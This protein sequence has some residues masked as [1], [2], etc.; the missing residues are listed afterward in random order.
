[1]LIKRDVDGKA[2]SFPNGE[3]PAIIGTFTYTAK[4]MGGAPS[5]T[6]TIYYPTPLD[7]QWTHEEYVEFQGE[8]YYA[9]SIPSSSK[10][11]QSVLYKHDV[12]F[13]SRREILDN[14]L[15]FDAV[16]NK[17][18]DT[19]GGDKY[20]TN[21][22]RFSF[23]GDITEFVSRINSS[24]KYCDV[25]YSVVIDDGYANTDV[26]EVSFENQYLT[27]VLQLINT[28]YQ[29]DYY[30]V[31]NV[32]HVGKLQYDL[33]DNPIEYGRNDA[34]V[35]VSKGNSNARIVDMITGYGSSDNIPYYYPNDD[36]FGKADYISENINEPIDI[37][38]SQ[39]QKNANIGAD[40][41][42]KY[43]LYKREGALKATINIDGSFFGTMPSSELVV[44]DG[45][46]FA[47]IAVIPIVAKKGMKIYEPKITVSH[48]T[49]KSGVSI[50]SDVFSFYMDNDTEGKYNGS[51]TFTND[52]YAALV[53]WEDI[54]IKSTI[55]DVAVDKS[56]SYNYIG[57]VEIE[58]EN[59]SKAFWLFD[60]GVIEY[61]SSGISV[62]NID[63]VTSAKS[64]VTFEKI[65]NA[66]NT[67]LWWGFKETYDTSTEEAAAKI[68]IKGR[69]WIF[70][71]Q[72]LMPS[73]YRESGGAERFYYAKNDTYSIPGAT[74]KYT[75]KNIYKEGNPHQGSVEFSDI[76]PTINGVRND[77]I[78][79]D[80]LGQLFGE[81]AGV[82]FDSNDSD[83]KNDDSEYIH[84]Y[85]YIKL[86]KFSGSYGFD[87]FKHALAS[88]SAKINLIKSNGCP[89]CSFDIQCVP[90]KDKSKMYNC[91]S[92]D[93]HGNLKSVRDDCNDYIFKNDEDA[94]K[95]TFNQDS[96]KTELWIAVKKDDSTL[97]IIMPNASGNFKPQKGD[98]FVITG[99]NPPKVLVTAAEKRLDDALIKYMS[100]N[101]E[102]KFNY[103]VKFSRIFLQENM[104]FAN[105]LNENSKVA[106]TYAGEK[107]EFFV[108]NYT[109]KVDD[110][111]LAD[112]EIELSDTLDASSS[113]LKKAID[114]VKG[115]TVAQL[116]GLIG[117]SGGLNATIANRLYL[118]KQGDDTAQ[119][120]ITF[121][122][123]LISDVLAK[124]NGGATFGKGGYKFDEKGNVVVDALSSLAFDEALERGFGVTKNSRGKYTLSVTDLMVWGKAVFNSLEIR[125]LYAVGGNVY[126]S[127]ASSKIVRAVPVKKATDTASSTG[128]DASAAWVACAEGDAD[129]EGWKCYTLND[130][131]TTATQNGWRKYDQA[132]C[133]TFDIEAGAHEGVSNTYYWRLVA[134][135]SM[136]NET[137][138]ETRTET[139]VDDDGVT[140]TREVT[141]DLYDGKKF[142]W[143]ILSKTDCES[144]GN[145]APKAGDTIVLD[146]HRMFASGDADG[147]DQY[148]DESRTNVMMLETTGTENGTLPRIVALTGIV[149]YRHWD[150]VN[151]YSNTV[152]ILSPKEVVFVSSSFK[153]MSA[154]GDPITLVNFR[155]NWAK[156]TKYGYYDQVSHNDSIWTCIVTKGD[157]TNEEPSDTS[158]VWRKEI[159]GGKGDPAVTYELVASPSY[160][161]LDADGSFDR[162]NQYREGQMLL[163]RGYKIVGGKRI[164][165][166]GDA[167]NPIS[168]QISF[169]DGAAWYESTF[170]QG[171]SGL[172]EVYNDFEP[173]CEDSYFSMLQ[174]M[175]KNGL[176]NCK[177]VMYEG[178]SLDPDK[179]PSDK[180]LARID[181]PIVQDGKDGASGTSYGVTL[182][183]EKRT[184]SSV[185]DDCLVVTFTKGDTDGV[186]TTN[187]VQD[188]GGYAQLYVDGKIDTSASARLN[189]GTSEAGELQ[190][191]AF[192][193]V[194]T[195]G[196]VTVKWYDKEGG[197]LLGTG[198]LTRGADGKDATVY[199]VQV[200]SYYEWT[201]GGKLPGLEFG[202]TKTTGATVGKVTDVRNIGCTVMIYGD[203]TYYSSAS[204]W[205]NEGNGNFL[206]STFPYGD[207]DGNP[208][209]GDASVVCVELYLDGMLVATANY[210]NGK[211]GADGPAATVYTIEAVGNYN[212]NSGT[213][214]DASTIGV[215]LT[216][217]LKLYKTVGSEKTEDSKPPQCWRLTVGGKNVDG[218]IVFT[219][220]A[221]NNIVT[222]QYYNTYKKDSNGNIA[223]PGSATI[224]VYKDSSMG[225]LLASLVIPITLNPGAIVNVDA[226]LGKI[227][228][229][230]ASMKGTIETIQQG[231]GQISL[232][233]QGLERKS[234]NILS[235]GN[236]IGLFNKQYEVFR[237]LPF[238]MEK[239]RTY[240][241]TARLWMESN[242]NERHVTAFVFGSDNNWTYAYSSAYFTKT[243]ADYLRF[244]FEA[245]ATRQMVVAFYEQNSSRDDPGSGNYNGVHV[246]WVRV[247]EGDWTGVD[248]N[249]RTLDKWEPSEEETNAVNLLPDPA[250]SASIGYTDGMG[251]RNTFVGSMGDAVP[252]MSRDPSADGDGCRGV[253]FERSG[254]SDPEGANNDSYAGL[255]YIVP[256]RGAGTYCISFVYTDLSQTLS[257]KPDMD[258]VVVMEVHP[259]DADKYRIT[260]GFNTGGRNTSSTNSGII[261]A[262]N[263]KTFGETATDGSGR[264]KKIAYL[265]VRVFLRGNGSVRVSRLCLSKSDH[266]IYWNANDVSKARKKEAALLAT[267]IDIENKKITLTADNTKFRD[268]DGN[269]LAVID[270]DGL[271]SSTIATTDTGHGHTVI[272]GNTTVW[273]QKDGKTPGIAVFYDAAGVP[274]LAF[275]GTDGKQKYDIGPSGLQSLISSIQQAHSDTAYLRDATSYVSVNNSTLKGFVW[276]YVASGEKT[277]K[278]YIYRKQIPTTDASAQSGIYDGCVFTKEYSGTNWPNGGNLLAN[279]WYV[280]PNDGNLPMKRH[281]VDE[282]GVLD[283][284]KT[285]YYQTFYY[286]EGGKVAR[287][288]RAYMKR[289][290]KSDQLLSK[291]EYAGS[292]DEIL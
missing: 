98:L 247:D 8:R 110:S 38:L 235:G 22:T 39:L 176:K 156:G 173:T 271:K 213:L 90:S 226:K 187:N 190:K 2:Q 7:K 27:E 106:I 157:T 212:N 115:E 214:V 68:T 289:S 267:G 224:S 291:F 58:Y 238:V 34:L 265:E 100:E 28:T 124:L 143:V 215:T 33:T 16:S 125:K 207:K 134:D 275:Y 59:Q 286:Y 266:F 249:G 63:N 216:G 196:Y 264:V 76:K 86:H 232:K 91:V 244:K 140:K 210:A 92:T 12:T 31:G 61:E 75:F 246:D 272:E 197:T 183:V 149:D 131:G 65:P 116:Q 137:I 50:K 3:V 290:T 225:E 178:E 201:S 221:G 269:E 168:I 74:D 132:K 223:V 77:V 60:G 280:T 4:R 195:A 262:Q 152:F 276:L 185:E 144:A 11:N 261:R 167:D 233:V 253:T 130:D 17:D 177:A 141:V 209:L 186:T 44:A 234:R 263:Y 81:I 163:V 219:N 1:M 71:S 160:I 254:Y 260:A 136:K 57:S 170:N 236:V 96:T 139:Y 88:E 257:G 21:Q 97:G 73:V 148:N 123:G 231:Q 255:R 105:K 25:P 287:T 85:F 9:T 35:S 242:S 192:P 250:F 32:C 155:G 151:P 277:D 237:S 274:H 41:A 172:D 228:S 24:M 229:T 83:V 48:H 282:E 145:D 165:Q 62:N 45:K 164:T 188:I 239:G 194:F 259:C 283:P 51:Y 189:L 93:G 89:A 95:D 175:K 288:V 64:L 166:W 193:Q 251:E 162:S 256:F 84:S 53:I 258:E 66:D 230:T 199:G 198:S 36:E 56:I 206:F 154:S 240:T 220:T 252:W 114:A 153:F 245:G 202:F 6:A 147:R 211:Q 23:G 43:T 52:R 82:A 243:S 18:E 14:T 101:N 208:T 241:V 99:I 135:V 222:Y 103:S 49:H 113:E 69:T 121:A 174:E 191:G 19:K 29:L 279:G 217:D 180:V 184:I 150:G 72:N 278:R 15:F 227:E 13:T 87:L 204:G 205:I 79:S 138:T 94:Y 203:G 54:T 80:G 171:E 111:A 40:Y 10:D 118:S 161:K 159:S 270:K 20:R 117:G 67:S 181:I 119:G 268:N 248:A 200:G 78:Q 104:A 292:Y 42:K 46:D 128:V 5:I 146:G 169:N 109:V 70:P 112:V 281:M 26:K 107:H 30:W 37:S 142:G 182:T 284:T 158:K 179:I 102:D 122:K 120:L 126:L 133:Q 285:L 129:C 55:G 47:R 127:G 108:T 273:F 218:T